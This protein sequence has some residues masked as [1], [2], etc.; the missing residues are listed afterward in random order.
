MERGAMQR[1]RQRQKANAKA[2]PVYER[3]IEKSR[4]IMV[5]GVRAGLARF[6]AAPRGP[7]VGHNVGH[8]C[9]RHGVW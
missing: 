3:L 1:Q 6:A 5:N 7:H 4:S 9:G 8:T 2:L